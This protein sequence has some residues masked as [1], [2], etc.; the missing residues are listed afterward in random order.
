MKTHQSPVTILNKSEDRPYAVKVVYN[1]QEKTL[2]ID[3]D[4]GEVFDHIPVTR[5]Q[6]VKMLKLLEEFILHNP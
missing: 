5:K 1:N 3:V 2:R 4:D 6:A